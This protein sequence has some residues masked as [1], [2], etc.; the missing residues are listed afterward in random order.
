M[1]DAKTSLR[2]VRQV[3]LLNPQSFILNPGAFL[4]LV[5]AH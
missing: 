4:N 5:E 3:H 1:E 2:H